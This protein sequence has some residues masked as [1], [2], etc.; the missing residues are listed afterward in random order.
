M[1]VHILMR[2]TLS[3]G[4]HIL[5]FDGGLCRPQRLIVTRWSDNRWEDGL[6]SSFFQYLASKKS[7][8]NPRQ[9]QLLFTE[10]QLSLFHIGPISYKPL[11]TP[12]KLPGA[13]SISLKTHFVIGS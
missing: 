2:Q 10:T 8:V 11:P 12:F 13:K 7:K 3:S 6:P 4:L 5:T 1:T 9:I